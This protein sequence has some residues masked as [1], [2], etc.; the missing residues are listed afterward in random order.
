MLIY[1]NP[2]PHSY[3]TLQIF[4]EMYDHLPHP[5]IHCVYLENRIYIFSKIDLFYARSVVYYCSYEQDEANRDG[6]VV[7]AEW[8][9]T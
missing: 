8:I 1:P 9:T 7:V 4:K 3:Y 5:I 2:Y 6:W